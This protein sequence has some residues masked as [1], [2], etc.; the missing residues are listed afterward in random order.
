M[1]KKSTLTVDDEYIKR[2]I[3]DPNVEI[4]K[5]YPTG[6]MQSYKTTLSDKDIS[7]IIEYLKTLHDK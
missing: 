3:Y 7:K 4:V 2:A 1:G 5:G 6:L